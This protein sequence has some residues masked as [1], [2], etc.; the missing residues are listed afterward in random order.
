MNARKKRKEAGFDVETRAT[1]ANC[2][3][4]AST[5]RTTRVKNKKKRKGCEA[6]LSS[7]TDDRLKAYG[8]NPK[9]F[10]YFHKKKLLEEQR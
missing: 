3:G 2:A 9:K 4:D 5:Q 1:S 8:I 6:K 10:K 7:I